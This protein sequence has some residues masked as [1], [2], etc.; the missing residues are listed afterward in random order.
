MKKLLIVCITLV[1]FVVC[2]A[3]T[4]PVSA[5]KIIKEACKEAGLQNKKALIIF[6]ASWCVWCH[7]LDS[8]INDVTCKKFFDDNYVIKHITVFE[9]NDKKDLNNPGASEFLTAHHAADQGIPAWFIFDS[10]GTLLADSQLRPAGAAFNLEG[11]NIGCPANETEI[12]YFVSIL[13][14]TSHITNEQ[15]QAIRKRFAENQMA[16]N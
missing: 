13:E 9:T 8:S 15:K 5:E 12:N 3:Q 1:S 14:K 7:K 16:S 11:S 6:H 4:Q 2:K 10:K